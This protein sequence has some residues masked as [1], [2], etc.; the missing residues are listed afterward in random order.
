MNTP[1]ELLC[2]RSWRLRHSAWML[3][4]ILS[5]GMLS[6][7]GFGYIGIKARNRTWLLIAAGALAGLVIY[8]VSSSIY[9]PGPK[10][11]PATL[12]STLLGLL[13]VVLWVGSTATA[14]FVNRQW[15]VWRAHNSSKAWYATATGAPSAPTDQ[16]PA[17]PPVPVHPDLIEVQLRT[18]VE[19][20]AVV[21]VA[22]VNLNSASREQ[23]AELP[24][25]DP[26][27]VERILA[28]RENTGGFSSPD[29][30]MTVAQIQP[31]VYVGLRS[32]VVVD[33]P[34]GVTSEGPAAGRKLEF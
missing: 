23:L 20:P 15:L 31:H 32:S 25:L 4:G 30:L 17:A 27:G 10:G 13:I 8:S 21:P 33:S 12:S 7:V 2:R 1:E 3:W 28:A 26:A 29:Q 19:L 24:G 14:F 34:A 18:A 6:F 5:F 9:P 16:V 22:A 11:S